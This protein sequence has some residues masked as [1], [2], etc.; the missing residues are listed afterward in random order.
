MHENKMPE[1]E[2]VELIYS[3]HFKQLVKENQE[4]EHVNLRRNE[5]P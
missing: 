3:N 2:I 4:I 5:T 1:S